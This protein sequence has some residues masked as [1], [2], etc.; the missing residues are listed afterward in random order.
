MTDLQQYLADCEERLARHATALPPE[1]R[2]AAGELTAL[3]PAEEIRA[4]AE[5]GL[6]LASHSLRSWEAAIEYFRVSPQVLPA[7]GTEAF[8][9]WVHAGRDLAEYSSLAAVAYFRASPGCIAHLPA[10]AQPEPEQGS[11]SVNRQPGSPRDAIKTRRRVACGLRT[12]G[13]CCCHF[14]ESRTES[15]REL[16]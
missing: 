11:I 4:W 7:L 13:S 3:L 6:S 8:R 2:R 10:A 15:H 5:E 14:V 9:R 16:P 12:A 1:F